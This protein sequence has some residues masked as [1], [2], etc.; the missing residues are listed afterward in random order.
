MENP[1]SFASTDV[2]YYKKHCAVIQYL[3]TT[4]WMLVLDA[5]TGFATTRSS[6]YFAT[7]TEGF[8]AFDLR[9]STEKPVTIQRDIFNVISRGGARTLIG[10]SYT[11]LQSRE[12]KSRV[13][14]PNHCIEEW[15]DDRVSVILIERFFSYEFSAGNYLSSRLLKV[16]GFR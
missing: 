10:G 9:F 6:P 3:P 12:M 16:L 1:V 11:R 4:D 13:V 8:G 14:N 7:L 15:I 2:L 5:D